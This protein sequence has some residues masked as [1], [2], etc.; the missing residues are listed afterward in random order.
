M[1]SLSWNSFDDRC[2][3]KNCTPLPIDFDSDGR[4]KEALNGPKSSSSTKL[5][6]VLEFEHKECQ[7]AV[8]AYD[9]N[10]V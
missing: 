1:L 8:L 4:G 5:L 6:L 2:L 3:F 7:V 10:K 9:R